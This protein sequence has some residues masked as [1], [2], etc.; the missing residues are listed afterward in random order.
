VQ[1]DSE[2]VMQKIVFVS[3]P[4]CGTHLLLRYF[5]LAGFRHAGPYGQLLYDEP[6]EVIDNLGYGDYSAWHYRWSQ[7]FLGH[8]VAAGAKVVFLY[9]DPRAYVV[10]SLH[11]VLRTR[12]HLLHKLFVENLP[13]DQERLLRLIRGF[14][15][16]EL[17]RFA[18]PTDKRYQ[19]KPEDGKGPFSSFRGHVGVQGT[20]V[21]NVYRYYARWLDEPFVFPVR[22]EDIIGPQGG[23]SRERQLTVL[24]DLLAFTGAREGSPDAEAL[25]GMLFSKDAA[26]FRKGQI[27]SWREEFTPELY[28]VFL[29]ESRELLELWGYDPE[30]GL[31]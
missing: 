18:P 8:I 5:D 25:A 17:L 12:Q 27:G 21:N 30:E 4:K 20:G 14:T 23:G 19:P 10:S 15:D 2:A 3:I 1:G 6:Y 31:T 28:E 9:R 22:F 11:H 16:E 13:S 26:T 29:Q 7:R 24:Q